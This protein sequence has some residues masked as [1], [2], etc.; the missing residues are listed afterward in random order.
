MPRQGAGHQLEVTGAY[1]CLLLKHGE[2]KVIFPEQDPSGADRAHPAPARDQMGVRASCS[3][4]G[5]S[6]SHGHRIDRG[7]AVPPEPNSSGRH[8]HRCL[9]APGKLQSSISSR[10][11][12]AWREK[13]GV[14]KWDAAKG[15]RDRVRNYFFL[16]HQR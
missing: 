7:R 3:A 8:L 11:L 14:S 15:D 5:A 4:P 6:P 1:A 12:D 2:E 13:E 16:V 10:S 9:P